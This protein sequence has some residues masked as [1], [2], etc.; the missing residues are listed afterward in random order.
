MNNPMNHLGNPMM[1]GSIQSLNAGF[2]GY[3]FGY[4]GVNCQPGYS[5]NGMMNQTMFGWDGNCGYGQHLPMNMAQM[6]QNPIAEMPGQFQMFRMNQFPMNQ[7][8]RPQNN[9][10]FVQPTVQQPG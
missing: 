3:N 9:M 5:N 2:N 7:Q 10:S 8:P 1:M 6:A 4:P